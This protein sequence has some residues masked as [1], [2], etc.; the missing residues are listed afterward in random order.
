MESGPRA[1]L[2]GTSR[3]IGVVLT[4]GRDRLRPNVTRVVL[5]DLAAG[6]AAEIHRCRR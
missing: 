2:V 1:T 6:V 3:R 4:A 5:A